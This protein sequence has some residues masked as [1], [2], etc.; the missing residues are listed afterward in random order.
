MIDGAYCAEHPTPD[1]YTKEWDFTLWNVGHVFR[2]SDVYEA[3]LECGR[4]TVKPGQT[5]GEAF[6]AWADH[7]MWLDYAVFFAEGF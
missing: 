2:W 3:W 5:L 4:C 7:P 1:G 6:E